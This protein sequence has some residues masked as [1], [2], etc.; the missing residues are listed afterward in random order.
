[1]FGHR[2]LAAKSERCGAKCTGPSL[3]LLLAFT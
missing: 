2:Y 3:G 1:L